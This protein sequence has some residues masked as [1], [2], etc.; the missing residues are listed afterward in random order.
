MKLRIVG[1]YLPSLDKVAML[2]AAQTQ[3]ARFREVNLDLIS[4]GVSTATISDVEERTHEY[5]EEIAQG[6]ETAALFE[7]A[8][9]GNSEEFDGRCF[10]CPEN[11][12][13]GWSPTFLTKDGSRRL[14]NEPEETTHESDFRVLFFINDW[15]NDFTLE[16]PHGQL[17]IPALNP[18]P[19]H[20]WKLAAYEALD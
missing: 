8:V 18:V 17:R 7:V 9:V 13:Y 19:D 4:Q 2:A 20:V 10:Y 1:A 12:G 11:D 14:T 6:L 3:A 5:A 16:G 15:D